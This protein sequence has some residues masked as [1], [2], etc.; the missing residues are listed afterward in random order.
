VHWDLTED[1]LRELFSRLGRIKSTTLVYDRQDRSTG[2]AY[3]VYMDIRDARTAIQEFDGAN[4]NGQPIRL[5]LVP[6]APTK[7][8]NPFDN[9]ERPSRSLYERIDDSERRRRAAPE[10]EDE[11][12]SRR[13]N[14]AR[15]PPEHID[16]YIPGEDNGARRRSPRRDGRGR[17]RGSRIP[18][19]RRQRDD[20][21]V[22]GHPI[23]QGRPR[24]TAEELD[25]E[26]TD[27]WNGQQAE[28][29]NGNAAPTS[30]NRL[31]GDIDMDI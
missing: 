11:R 24:K 7:P 29:A 13:S 16:R 3:V 15:P 14:V 12:P 23:V 20:K 18:G 4:A 1:D 9:V 27:Y 28:A 31:D 22:E 5:T 10:S 17:G 19:Q 30:V 25:A 21:D 6:N 2:V 8:R 26:M